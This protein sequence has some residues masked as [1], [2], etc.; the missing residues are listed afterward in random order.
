MNYT[1]ISEL[2]FINERQQIHL[3]PVI[4]EK[5]FYFYLNN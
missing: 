2:F 1:T 3:F 4:A 5:K